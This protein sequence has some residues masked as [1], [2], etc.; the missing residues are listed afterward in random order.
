[1]SCLL[2][3]CYYILVYNIYVCVSAQMYVKGKVQEWHP[4]KRI[5]LHGLI[6]HYERLD[7]IKHSIL[8]WSHIHN[9]NPNSRN[10]SRYI[11]LRKEN[12]TYP[13]NIKTHM[14]LENMHIDI[15]ANDLLCVCVGL[16]ECPLLIYSQCQYPMSLGE[17]LSPSTRRQNLSKL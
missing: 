3:C 12:A 1:M 8:H 16:G 17:Q 2:S 7:W 9:W 4:C 5:Y 13:P 6:Q 10:P 14:I 11:I 15:L